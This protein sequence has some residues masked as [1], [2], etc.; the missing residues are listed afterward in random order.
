MRNTARPACVDLLDALYHYS[1][2]EAGCPA[3]TGAACTCGYAALAAQVLAFVA[4]QEP[5]PP[6]DVDS[7]A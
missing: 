4:R 3:R 7:G 2:H 5:T 1:W 6:V